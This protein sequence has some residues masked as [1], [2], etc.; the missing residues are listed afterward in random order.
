MIM[1]F[2]IPTETARCR[3]NQMQKAKLW[4]IHERRGQ[5]MWTRH[6]TELTDVRRGFFFVFILELKFLCPNLRIEFAP[7]DHTPAH[8]HW[9][10]DGLFI[11]WAH[12]RHGPMFWFWLLDTC[13]PPQL[14][15]RP[16]N[17][18]KA[19]STHVFLRTGNRLQALRRRARSP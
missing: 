18:F 2:C 13:L 6:T 16:P 17:A 9:H 15:P 11:W 1:S 3:Y 10:R 5:I 4:I 19:Y 12:D 8:T 7:L 14:P